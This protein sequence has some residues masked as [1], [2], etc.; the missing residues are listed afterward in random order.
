MRGESAADHWPLSSGPLE[1]LR[2]ENEKVTIEEEVLEAARQRA[3]ALA[4]GDQRM[5]RALLHPAFGWTSHI[6]DQF[7]RDSYLAANVGGPARWHSQVL[8]ETRVTVVGDT[9]VLRGTVTDD[10]TTHAGRNKYRMLMTQTWVRSEG[11]WRCLAGHA[12]PR[13]ET[14]T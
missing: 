2:L 13:F 5:L 3:V 10:V 12:G 4:T 6:G 1:A 7:D 14:L 8:T 9:A 11:R